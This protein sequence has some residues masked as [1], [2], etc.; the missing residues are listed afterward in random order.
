MPVV[1]QLVAVDQWIFNR[2]KFRKKIEDGTW[3][4]LTPE[5]L[6]EGR[7]DLHY[8]L[9]GDDAFAL[10]PLM[11]KH[12]SRRQLTRG[13]RRANNRISRGKRVVEIRMESWQADSGYYRHNGAK[14]KGCQ[15]HC[16]DTC[17]VFKCESLRP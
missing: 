1:S 4:L 13:E 3:G 7:P 16:F 5:L 14:A 17:C 8:F 12:Y 2:S 6:G 11:V 15:R 10:M 9:L